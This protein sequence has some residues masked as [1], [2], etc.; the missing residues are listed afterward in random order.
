MINS[1][2]MIGESC[3]KYSN[4]SYEFCYKRKC[5]SENYV[6]SDIDEMTNE[7]VKACV[8]VTL[9]IILLIIICC[10]YCYSVKHNKYHIKFDK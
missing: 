6:T 8:V 10:Y 1:D 5:I 2:R 7:I 3:T 9:I 4:C